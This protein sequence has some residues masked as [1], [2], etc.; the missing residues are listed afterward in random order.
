M[1]CITEKC[2][3]RVRA[4]QKENL[5]QFEIR[6]YCNTHTCDL[7]DRR[8][9]NRQATSVVDADVSLKVFR[10]QQS[11]PCTKN[12]NDVMQNRGPGVS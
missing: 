12:N 2:S 10:R 4:T 5:T 6:I 8:R 1:R 11:H 7:S 3:W 9:R